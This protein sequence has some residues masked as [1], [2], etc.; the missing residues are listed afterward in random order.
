[1]K[2]MWKEVRPGHHYKK[3]RNGGVDI[4][5]A[6]I[7]GIP[8]DNM[9]IVRFWQDETIMLDV[10]LPGSESEIKTH[11]KHFEGLFYKKRLDGK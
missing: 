7:Q 5:R 6:D 11:L 3:L 2:F 10:C 4:V 9:W 1:M 8:Q